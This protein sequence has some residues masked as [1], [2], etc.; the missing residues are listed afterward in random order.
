[1]R[2]AVR[3]SRL[4]RPSGPRVLPMTRS[5][6]ACLF[7]FLCV[8]TALPAQ[9]D[10]EARLDAVKEF[11]K[12]V[13]KT[14]DE[15]LLREAVLTHLKGNECRP[16]AEEL[17]KLLRHPSG[18]VQEAAFEVLGTYTSPTTYEVWIAELPKAKDGEQAALIVKVLGNAK[19]KAGVDAIEAAANDPRATPVVKFEAARALRAIG[20]AGKTP[21][22]GNL[23]GD[24]EPQV[25]MAALD[26]VAALKLK[27]FGKQVTALIADPEW[28]VQTAAI[29]AAAKLRPQEAVQPLIDLMR[30]T[31]RLR[32]ECADALFQITGLDFGVDPDRWQE[33]WNSLMSIAGWR[34][35]T[36]EEIAQKAASRKKY[37]E[38]YGKVEGATT[39]AKI[40][41][42]SVNVLFVIDVSGSMDDLVV[43]RE[44]FQGYANFKKFTIVQTELINAIES[45]SA[46]TNFDI[47]AFATDLHPWKKRLVPANIVNKDAAKSHVKGLRPIGGSEAQ[48]SAMSG[49]GGSANLEA[50]KTNTLKALMYP[51][52]VDPEKPVKAVITGFD[53]NAIKSPLDTVYFL[54]DGR[55]SVGKLIETNEIL[56][57]V[58]KH[59]EIFRMV[60]HCIAIGDFTKE[61]MKQLAEENGG[62][63]VDLGR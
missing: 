41:T 45:L 32:T 38:L 24:K 17:F 51:F 42:T 34:I 28:Q 63:F 4:R 22:L 60:L 49:L 52:G 29:A 44:K 31:G 3:S 13:R 36:D 1:M 46:N 61:F 20:D 39:F 59:N 47:V 25:R 57:E 8:L 27:Q 2:A 26:T 35:P 11:Q 14:K 16:A 56:A 48:E 62:V 30:Q 7:A 50:G 40:P 37:D 6:S 53:K 33:Q 23:L 15:M 12:Y 21:L 18:P 9:Q 55:P 43:E 19:V 5:L 54:S 10:L 58:R